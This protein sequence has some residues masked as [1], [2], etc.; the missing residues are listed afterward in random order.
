MCDTGYSVKRLVEDLKELKA[1][2]EPEPALLEEVRDRVKRLLL[3][4]HNWLRPRMRIVSADPSSPG[5]YLLHEEDD[6]S[7]AVFVVT[8]APGE[9]TPPHEHGTWAVIAGLEGWET[10]HRWKRVDGTL[11]RDGS[12]RI[13]SNVVVALGT[14]AIHSVHN[15]SGDVSVTLHVYGVHP[16]HAVPRD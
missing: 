4:K 11:V 14:G 15:E 16:D 13:D 5:V 1:R 12:E 3:M 2:G 9:E 8:W 7:L 6:H 10:Q